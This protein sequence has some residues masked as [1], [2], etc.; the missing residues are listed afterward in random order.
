MNQ[1]MKETIM[2]EMFHFFHADRSS[3]VNTRKGLYMLPTLEV[4]FIVG[5][6]SWLTEALTS[7]AQTI[8]PPQSSRQLRLQALLALLMKEALFLVENLSLKSSCC[9][10]DVVAHTCNPSTVE[11]SQGKLCADLRGILEQPHSSSFGG[12][13]QGIYNSDDKL[14]HNL[15]IFFSKTLGSID[16]KD[17]MES[18]S[19]TQAGVQWRNLSSLQPPLPGFKLE[20]SGLILAHCNLCLLGSSDSLASA[21]QVARITGKC[22]HTQPIFVFLVETG[23][24]HVGQAGLEFLTSGDLPALAS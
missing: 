20:C 13:C 11:V 14:L 1:H 15:K 7:W 9:W 23:F 3:K 8:L 21:S 2:K 5:A 10:P 19:V 18:C 22:Y 24:R 6:Q 12:N 16:H 4:A 17:Q